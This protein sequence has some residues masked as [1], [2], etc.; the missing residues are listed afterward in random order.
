V[1]LDEAAP[2]EHHRADDDQRRRQQVAGVPDESPDSVDDRSAGA[3]SLPPQVHERREEQADGGEPEAD[4]LG[5]VVTA[6]LGRALTPL[7]A[8]RRARSEH[9]LRAPLCH[10]PKLRRRCDES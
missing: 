6:L 7:H 9:A 10:A 3:A 4:Q 5:M 8:R 2:A 1:Y